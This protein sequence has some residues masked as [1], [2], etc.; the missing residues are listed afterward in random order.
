ME[1][2]VLNCKILRGALQESREYRQASS[3][4]PDSA[5]SPPHRAT[6]AWHRARSPPRHAWLTGGREAARC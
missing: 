2:E 5:G 3:A 6:A 4:M 1:Q